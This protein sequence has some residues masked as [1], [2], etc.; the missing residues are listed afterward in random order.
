MAE[1]ISSWEC[2]QLLLSTVKTSVAMPSGDVL[3]EA[4]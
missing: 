1:A 4:V 3:M 2:L